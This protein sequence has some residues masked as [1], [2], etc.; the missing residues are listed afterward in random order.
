MKGSVITSIVLHGLLFTLWLL[1]F[2]TQAR[3]IGAGRRDLHMKLGIAGMLLAAVL[4]PLMYLTAVGGVARASA[5]PFTTPL[6]WTAVPLACLAAYIPLLW[7]GW[8]HRRN[9]AAHKR[10]MLCAA[11]LMMGPAVGRFPIAPPVLAGHAIQQFLAWCTVIPLLVYDRRTLGQ[12]HWAT[13]LG[14]SLT[15]ASVLLG[16]AGIVVPGW[17]ALAAHLPGV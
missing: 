15:G 12:L 6:A 17:A 9:A 14:A 13:K 10:L 16:I 2:W 5:P 11:L 8:K 3:L 7:L 4:I 1:V